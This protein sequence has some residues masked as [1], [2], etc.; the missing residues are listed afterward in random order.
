MDR[1][2]GRISSNASMMATAK[3]G[4]FFCV[5]VDKKMP[6][7]VRAARKAVIAEIDRA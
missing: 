3:K 1:V 5:Q 7:T 6:T 4:L 2:F